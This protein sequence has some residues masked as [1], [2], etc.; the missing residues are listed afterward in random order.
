MNN[1]LKKILV[2]LICNRYTNVKGLVQL[3]IIFQRG[4]STAGE[5]RSFYR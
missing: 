2:E 1:E 4:L 5:A 3:K